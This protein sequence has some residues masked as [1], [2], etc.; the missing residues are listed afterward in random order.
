VIDA[1]CGRRFYST[2]EDETRY[3]QTNSP[4]RCYTDDIVSVTTLACDTSG[5]GT[6]DETWTSD[7]YILMPANADLDGWPY[8]WIE[9]AP[10]GGYYFP[11]T[12][13]NPHAIQVTGK[14]GF[15]ATGS[16]PEPVHSACI[17]GVSQVFNR[18]S[19]V[20]GVQGG[21]GLVHRLR[22]MLQAD[23]MWTGLLEPY[24]RARSRI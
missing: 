23:V 5:D 3:Y 14:F 10:G 17:L 18:K 24:V 8:L 20:Y 19:S 1:F 16:Y 21:A 13:R 9:R 7:D 11:V 15:N 22:Y 4:N 2:A 6:A 12:Q